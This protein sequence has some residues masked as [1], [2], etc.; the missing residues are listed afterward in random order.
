[1]ESA[2]SFDDLLLRLQAGDPDAASAIFHRYA[3]RLIGLASKRLAGML[4]QKVDAEDLVQSAFKSFFRANAAAPYPVRNWDGLWSLLA[5]IT[6][7]K[8]GYQTRHFLTGKRNVRNEV[9]AAPAYEDDSGTGCVALAREPT[10]AEAAVLGDLV[11]TLLASLDGKTR[12]IMELV[13]QGH[14]AAEIAPLVA[15]TERSVFRRMERI[16]TQ[17]EKLQE[18]DTP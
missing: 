13:L 16:R 17:F 12:Q 5:M 11:E 8:C 2:N 1:M 4:R 6:L 9:V 15:L 18:Q 14:S 7:R 10:P 3:H